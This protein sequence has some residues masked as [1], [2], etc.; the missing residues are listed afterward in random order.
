M[1][2]E[3]IQVV[4]TNSPMSKVHKITQTSVK[5][6]AILFAG[7]RKPN[8]NGLNIDVANVQA[9]F[10]RG[11]IVDDYLMTSNENI[12]AIGDCVQ[13]EHF[14]HNS[15]IHARMVVRNALFG[16]QNSKKDIILPRVTYT[17]PEVAH[18]G[19]T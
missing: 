4:L 14:T 9:D 13:G 5:V 3:N 11:I 7:G 15:D 12:F 17:D 1:V 18:V 16:K 2:E 6:D 8:L 19:K 10:E